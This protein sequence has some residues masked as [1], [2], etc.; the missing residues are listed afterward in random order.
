MSNRFFLGAV[1]CVSLLGLLIYLAGGEEKTI[2][3]PIVAAS[4]LPFELT[5][6]VNEQETVDL[7]TVV[8]VTAGKPILVF[9]TLRTKPGVAFATSWE[10]GASC[11]E[12]VTLAPLPDPRVNY[13]PSPFRSPLKSPPPDKPEHLH[14]ML[15]AVVFP[16]GT[17]PKN[18]RHSEFGLVGEYVDPGR[19]LLT[20][21]GGLVCPSRPG[22]YTLR[23]MTAY[24]HER[25]F[26]KND[27][28]WRCGE[29]R[30]IREITIISTKAAE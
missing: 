27:D 16:F 4:N 3:T 22:K 24:K 13:V 12:G 30:P 11:F 7:T 21:S 8:E 6:T 29:Y 19:K 5:L 2:P 10:K 9:G 14:V 17:E 1:L 20:F 15:M 28:R 18:A 25:E 26:R 23:L